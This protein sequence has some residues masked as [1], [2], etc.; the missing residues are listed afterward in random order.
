MAAPKSGPGAKN[1]NSKT[2]RKIRNRTRENI[3][4]AMMKRR[5]AFVDG[6]L[7]GLPKYQAAMFAGVPLASAHKEGCTMWSEPYVQERFQQLREKLEEEQLITRK[8]AILGLK[9]EALY[10]GPG[11]MHGA[12]VSAW[13]QLARVMGYE[14]KSESENDELAKTLAS[15]IL[16]KPD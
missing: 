16:S 1:P 10:D 5:D 2:Q 11:S 3:S 4:P 9:S 14:K 15:L 12:R 8:E 6:L 7:R 13:G